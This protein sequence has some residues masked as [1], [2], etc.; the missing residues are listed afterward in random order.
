MCTPRERTCPP[1]AT[2][3]VTIT[4][5]TRLYAVLGR[6]VA[7]SASPGLYNTWFAH[8][9]V[10]AR[11]GALD[12]PPDRADRVPDALR[13]LGLAGANLTVP[14]KEAVIP[15]LDA[16]APSAQRA[17]AVNVIRREQGRLVGHN[18]DGSGL[19]S[20]LCGL[21]FDETRPALVLGAGGAGRAAVGALLDAGLP[22]VY[23][24]N[25]TTARARAVAEQL[26]S[27]VR[28]GPLTPEAFAAVACE[29][30][31]VVQAVSGPGRVC[32]DALDPARLSERSVLWSDLNYWDPTPPHHARLAELGHRFDDGWGMLVGQAI[33]A[34][35]L[36]TGLQLSRLEAHALLPGRT[37]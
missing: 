13:T 10:D 2:E 25:R 3:H 23:L 15:H 29:V 11:Y 27:R 35:E 9:G 14:L 36:F 21:G 28:P 30:G 12:V 17:G 6:P 8:F 19:R 24:L 18:T 16:L 37:P 26:G 33:G 5:H 1:T 22:V 32:I 20:H 4:G 31:L 34:F 7:H